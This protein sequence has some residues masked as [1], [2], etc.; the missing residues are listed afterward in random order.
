MN[1]N[2]NI[3]FDVTINEDSKYVNDKFKRVVNKEIYN[4]ALICLFLLGYDRT[5]TKKIIA[6]K[7]NKTER[8]ANLYITR[9]YKYFPED[10]LRYTFNPIKYDGNE[11]KVKDRKQSF[12]KDV[13]HVKTVKAEQPKDDIE[14]MTYTTTENPNNMGKI[15]IKTNKKPLDHTKNT[16]IRGFFRKIYRVLFGD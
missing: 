13:L 6:E 4:T 16:G 8:T 2:K 11:T 3:G 9:L 1:L 7:F 15:E 14:K 12:I 10:V 5:K